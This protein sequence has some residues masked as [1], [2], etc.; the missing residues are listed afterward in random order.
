M[1]LKLHVEK[2]SGCFWSGWWKVGDYVVIEMIHWISKSTRCLKMESEKVTGEVENVIKLV[3]AAAKKAKNRFLEENK[4]RF[5]FSRS[6][7]FSLQN[8][9]KKLRNRMSNTFAENHWFDPVRMCL[10]KH[11]L[12]S[13]KALYWWLMTLTATPS[14]SLQEI[15]YFFD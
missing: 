8:R 4:W 11:R 13:H 10:H 15:F 12:D 6:K 5:L 14:L 2:V 3:E 7:M 1:H 9:K